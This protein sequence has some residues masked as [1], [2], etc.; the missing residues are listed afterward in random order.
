MN[1]HVEYEKNG[2]SYVLKYIDL[3]GKN[4]LGTS[5]NYFK[6]VKQTENKVKKVTNSNNTFVIGNNVTGNYGKEEYIRK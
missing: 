4:I 2:T 1:F 3:D 6:L 5:S